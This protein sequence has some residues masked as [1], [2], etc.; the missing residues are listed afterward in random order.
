MN[1]D[2]LKE[3]WDPEFLDDCLYKA[4]EQIKKSR[5]DIKKDERVHWRQ[6]PPDLVLAVAIKKIREGE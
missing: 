2:D 6:I 3:L 1:F 5:P 4:G